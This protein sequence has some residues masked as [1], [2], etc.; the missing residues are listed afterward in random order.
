MN[1]T[2]DSTPSTLNERPCTVV[3]Q[4]VGFLDQANA[5]AVE[6]SL[7]QALE[8]ATTG[9]IVDLLWIETA[10]ADGICAL[11]RSVEQAAELNKSIVFQSM[12]RRIQ[13]AME[14]EWEQRRMIRLGSWQDCFGSDLE[15]FLD[16]LKRGKPQFDSSTK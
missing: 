13:A 14:A 9:V 6:Q 16:N 5:A 8:L 11:I 12:S 1:T 3:V 10:D 15:Q 2:M 7:L 4:P